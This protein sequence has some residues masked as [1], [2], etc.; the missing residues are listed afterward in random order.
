MSLFPDGLKEAVSEQLTGI[1]GNEVEIISQNTIGGGCINKCL[2]LNTTAGPFFIKWNIASKF[3]NMFEAEAKGLNLLRGK[4]GIKVPEVY[5]AGTAG[6]KSF[7]IMEYFE[8]GAGNALFFEEFGSELAQLH[9]N[10]SKHFGLEHENYIGSLSQLNNRIADWN[11]FFIENRLKPQIKLSL[12]GGFFN[13]NDINRFENLYRELDSIFPKEKPSLLHGDLWSGNFMIHK[14]G[15][16]AYMDPA[17]YYGHREAELSFTTLFG[18]FDPSFYHAYD[19]AFPLENGFRQRI[20]IYNLYPLLVH[21][22]LFGWGY[23][24]QVK[25]IIEKF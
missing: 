11:G 14:S 15:N 5:K 8:T 6:G 4:C 7:L 1:T 19:L 21:V 25:N 24:G 20:D 18:G 9:Q 3:P 23:V 17:V 12:D 10:S 22:N 2:H 16:A 13:K